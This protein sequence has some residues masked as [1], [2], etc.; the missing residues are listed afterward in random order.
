MIMTRSK[1][2]V[3]LVAVTSIV[4][5]YSP[6]ASAQD[7]SVLQGRW[8]LNRELSE[9]PREIGFGVDWVSADGT[10]LG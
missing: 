10:G 1:L 8:N 3:V 7:P 6:P 4:I 5:Q 2:A 9:F